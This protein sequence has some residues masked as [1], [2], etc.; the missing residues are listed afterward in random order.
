MKRQKVRRGIV[1]ITFLTLPIVFDYFS[2]AIPFFG[3]IEGIVSGSLMFFGMLFLSSLLFGRAYCG[4]LCP[5]G[6]L[7]ECCMIAVDKK[8]KGGKL[9]LIKFFIWIPWLS[10][11]ILVFFLN[12]GIK[13]LDFTYITIAHHG[14]SLMDI[15]A[16]MVYYFCLTLALLICMLG[17][18]RGFCHYVCW[19]APFMI[20]GSRIRKHFNCSF[21]KLK[22]EPEKCSSCGLCNKNCPMSLDVKN[23]VQTKEMYN[24]E[25][26]LC[27]SCADTCPKKAIKL[28]WYAVNKMG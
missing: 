14:I 8:A 20:I 12:E 7:Q 4:W 11:I 27:G 15:K 28:S 17:G 2:P 5:V 10:A 9:N 16:Y 26:I 18:K 25:C 1:L 22:C 13:K 23:M 19:A 3:A 24:S 21:L 6:G